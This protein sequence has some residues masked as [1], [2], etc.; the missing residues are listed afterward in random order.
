MNVVDVLEPE[1][2][3]LRGVRLARWWM[4]G[5]GCVGILGAAVWLRAQQVRAPVFVT[6]RVERSEVVATVT[7][8]GALRAQST[9]EV[10]AEISGLVRAVRVDYNQ[11]VR[12]GQVLAE[13]DTAQ[14]SA[15]VREAS[16][17]VG[18]A[19]ATLEL[20][21]VG[22][23]ESDTVLARLT[24]LAEQGLA[25][26][27]DLDGAK[28]GAARA[29]AEYKSA[30][31][32]L[33]VAQASLLRAQTDHSHA[34]IRSP[35]DG[36]VLKRSIEPGQTVAAALQAPILFTLAQDLRRM[37]LHVNVDEADVGKIHEGQRASFHVDAYPDRDFEAVILSLRNA[38]ESIHN[39]VTYEALL[40][41]DNE[42]RALRP[43]MTAVANVVTDQRN[44]VLRVPSAAL[45]FKPPGVQ[46]GGKSQAEPDAEPARLWTLR[47]GRP[48]DLPVNVRG[49]D[50]DFTRVA[51]PEIRAG[52]EVLVD[53]KGQER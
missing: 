19:R 17:H 14:L 49:V 36:V 2:A 26:V 40:S 6:A 39:V 47:A 10:G 22:V 43:G 50:G 46:P 28:A 51:G 4:L 15:A 52:L 42:D 23:D 13:L 11:V 48:A 34:F 9:V 41:V 31:A 37:V 45:R 32:R 21:Q 1:Q 38:S 20:A 25:P 29:R 16:A 18:A 5:A 3:D 35:I 53:I 33:E 7:A 44:E 27:Q 8:S 30:E 12:Q 24:G